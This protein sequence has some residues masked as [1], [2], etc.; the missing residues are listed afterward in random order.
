M[1]Q[2]LRQIQALITDKV[3][4]GSQITEFKNLVMSVMVKYPEDAQPRIIQML[5]AGLRSVDS[6]KDFSFIGDAV[7]ALNF[8]S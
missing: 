1:N 7:H 2:T 4:N 6:I 3:P 8:C 5:R